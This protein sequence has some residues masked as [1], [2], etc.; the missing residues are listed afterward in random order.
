MTDK[1]TTRFTR[2]KSEDVS[3]MLYGKIPPASRELEEVVLGSILIDRSCII[4]VASILK[5]ESFYVDAHATIFSSILG[6]FA[7][8][9]P[10]DLLTVIEDLRKNAKLEECG[11]A[12]YLSEL[13][14]KVASSDNVEYHARIITQKFI[15]RE[16][17]RISNDI[18]REAYEDTTDVFDLLDNSEILFNNI[19]SSFNSS[20][21]NTALS[22]VT[23]IKKDIISPPE[24]PLFVP[25]TLGIKWNY[26]TVNAIG[27][28]PATGKTAFLIQSVI[29][30]AK[31]GVKSGII[32]AE[33][34]KRLLTSKMMHHYKGTFASKIIENNLSPE[35]TEHI[36][37]SNFDLFNSVFI[38]DKTTTNLNIRSKIITLVVKF[39]VKIVWIDYIQ[40]IRLVKDR[41]TTDVKAMEDLMNLLQETA[42][43][44]D[45]AIVVLSQMK[46]GWEKPTIEELR[47]GGIE[48]AC[49]KVYMLY[50][51]NA[52]QYDGKRFL[53]I[54]E[55]E[56]GYLELI[57]GKSRFDDNNSIELY[58]EKLQQVMYGWNDKPSYHYNSSI[59][60]FEEQT[61]K[62]EKEIVI[63][64]DP[65]KVWA[66]N[67]RVEVYQFE[68]LKDEAVEVLKNEHADLF[69]V[70][71]Y[72]KIIP[73]TV[74][75]LTKFGALNVHP[76]I[77]PE[78]RGASPLQTS[79][80]EDS[81]NV[82]VS[83]I[84][85][86]A[87]MDHG[88]IFAIKKVSIENW[89]VNILELKKILAT[90]G[91]NI[92]MDSLPQYLDGTLKLTEQDH[93]KA[94]FTKKIVKS[95]GEINLESDTWKNYL[96]IQAFFGWPG[97]FF[98]TERHEKKIRVKINKATFD[99]E[100]AHLIIERVTPEGGKEM[101]YEDFL[102]G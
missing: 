80:L 94:T 62:V 29:D 101:N 24:V 95:D 87:E 57:D 55:H 90:E 42:K 17:I 67:N 60:N 12:Y 49:S 39:G 70:A 32:S 4:T 19:K 30:A 38:E 7:K 21:V 1:R 69:I 79:I 100:N 54:P 3:T 18:I 13:T 48:A 14:N 88:P 76:S 40:L 20:T 63:K 85:M 84:K 72:G 96:K 102:R 51:K 44:L 22:V 5:P 11:G 15:Q 52:K 91:A 89:P 31:K 59:N 23:S 82:G 65:A 2:N 71:S 6:L 8:S 37:S 46:R 66:I 41:N 33:L 9:Q 61:Q 36:L 28:K 43:E 98:F 83:I 64:A 92:L 16:L 81:K 25:T 86:D 75:D 74:L 58:F 99:K 53:E 34:G 97:T 26:G 56:R 50:D 35:E 73:Q 47:G 77:L 93:S 45:I 78:Y 27:A 68:K 10:I